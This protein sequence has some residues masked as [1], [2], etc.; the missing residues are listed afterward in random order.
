MLR[1]EK[2]ASAIKRYTARFHSIVLLSAIFAVLQPLP[3]ASAQQSFR[4][5]QAQAA[6]LAGSIANEIAEAESKETEQK[7]GSNNKADTTTVEPKSDLDFFQ[8]FLKLQAICQKL[9]P[10]GGLPPDAS[11]A[12]E[13]AYQDFTQGLAR[14]R[15]KPGH[16]YSRIMR[17]R[18]RDD[19]LKLRQ[20]LGRALIESGAE[21]SE[22][23][24]P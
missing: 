8:D 20:A 2:K 5:E 4:F 23:Q 21:K 19:L 3:D 17:R 10:A 1:H 24:T 18:V 15:S 11:R 12:L 14:T 7:K 22:R 6:K 13:T 9:A 16:P